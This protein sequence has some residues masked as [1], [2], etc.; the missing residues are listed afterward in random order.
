[1]ISHGNRKNIFFNPGWET[2]IYTIE[3]AYVYNYKENFFLVN[4]F[5]LQCTYY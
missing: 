2:L 1:M 4:M 3:R 5:T